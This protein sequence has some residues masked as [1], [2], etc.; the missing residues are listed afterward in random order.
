MDEEYTNACCSETNAITRQNLDESMC[1]LAHEFNELRLAINNYLEYADDNQKV[2]SKLDSFLSYAGEI[3]YRLNDCAT[4]VEEFQNSISALN[5]KLDDY[6]ISMQEASMKNN[7]KTS[8]M[9]DMLE[10]ISSNI[11]SINTQ[12]SAINNELS[13]KR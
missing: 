3:L 9:R 7:T 6:F 8:Q 12:I 2:I 10:T 4:K 5:T 1:W 13:D 11:G